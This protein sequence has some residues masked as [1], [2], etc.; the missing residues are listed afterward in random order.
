[1]GAVVGCGAER[2]GR[3]SGSISR[4]NIA[5]LEEWLS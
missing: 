4:S 1:M 5:E 3:P 2:D